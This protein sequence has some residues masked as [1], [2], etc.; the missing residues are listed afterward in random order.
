M[1]FILKTRNR[2]QWITLLLIGLISFGVISCNN[3]GDNDVSPDDM[4]AASAWIYAYRLETPEGRVYYMSVH[5][6]IPS[7]S[8]VSEAVELGLN[9]RIYSYGEHPYTWN[10]DA[11]T[12]TKWN[13]DRTTLAL[14]VD[15]IVSF[16]TTGISGNVG[17]PVFLSET[18]S[19]FSNLEEGVVVEWNP[20]TMEIEKVHHVDPL[21]DTGTEIDWYTEW[22]KYP[23]SDGKILMPIEFGTPTVCCSDFT[24]PGVMVAIFDPAT[25]SIAYKHD[26]RL[27]S[28]GLNLLTDEN[29][30]MYLVPGRRNSFVIPYFDVNVNDLPN[31]FALLK[32]DEAGT[33]DPNFYV[34]LSDIIPI[35]FYASSIFVLDNKLVL[36]Y[37][38]ANDYNHPASFDQRWTVYATGKFKTVMIDL[39]TK[40]VTPFQAFSKYEFSGY[41]NTIDGKNYFYAGF[42]DGLI[43][44]TSSTSVY[45]RQD[46]INDYTVLTTHKGGSMS[47]IGKLW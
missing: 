47:H 30:V 4:E 9:N 31:P 15:G 41:A 43:T 8:N 14:S 20:S 3:D 23:T 28:S 6:E 5:E 25:S 42:S 35:A 19:F 40:E 38:D 26:D 24:K 46:G 36:T 12:I 33:F 18:Q 11:A 21:P 39:E 13:V 45:L 34:D 17:P 44:S 27:Y 22:F 7:E 10:G 1:K 2:W 37:V 32:V 29:G 16:A